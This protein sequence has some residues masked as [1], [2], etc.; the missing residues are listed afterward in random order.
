M[1]TSILT[2]AFVAAVATMTMVAA[3]VKTVYPTDIVIRTAELEVVSDYQV[4]K[5]VLD[6]FH[7]E[8]PGAK[9]DEIMTNGTEYRFSFTE[10]DGHANDATYDREGNRID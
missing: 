6:A 1:K 7:A 9:V 4:P 8:F 3:P 5:A 2:I 10:P